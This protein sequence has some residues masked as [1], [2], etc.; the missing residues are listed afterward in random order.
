MTSTTAPS[1]S[2]SVFTETEV[3]AD[4]D[5]IEHRMN[6]QEFPDPESKAKM[7]PLF[8]DGMK[9]EDTLWDL[10][11]E[12]RLDLD[13]ETAR[14]KFVDA[15]ELC[16]FGAFDAAS[17]HGENVSHVTGTVP[18][19]G[20]KRYPQAVRAARFIAR[21]LDFT[22]SLS[23]YLNR[24]YFEPFR[25]LQGDSYYESAA[26]F[27]FGLIERGMD[28]LAFAGITEEDKQAMHQYALLLRRV[29]DAR[30][31]R[32]AHPECFRR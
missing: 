27:A 5:L 32:R 25:T 7:D 9:G 2:I 12:V 19:T 28:L 21:N 8:C 26:I 23:R 1:A 24:H 10:F 6:C 20:A 3:L 31:A 16:A 18:R 22:E 29:K 17:K 11:G 30:I 15:L 13:N 4:D 14:R